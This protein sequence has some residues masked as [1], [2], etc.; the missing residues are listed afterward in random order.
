MGVDENKIV[1]AAQGSGKFVQT[2]GIIDGIKWEVKN[3]EFLLLK[4][5]GE[6][7]TN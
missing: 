4:G 3:L 1:E 6:G 2:L 5:L 7:R